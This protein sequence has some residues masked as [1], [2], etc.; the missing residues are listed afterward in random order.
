MPTLHLTNLA[1]RTQHGPGRRLCAMARPR[2]WEHGDGKIM[3]AMPMGY[4]LDAIHKGEI[5]LDTYRERCVAAFTYRHVEQDRF[6]P[7]RLR[8]VVP[9]EDG[10]HHNVPVVDGDTL[11]CACARPGSPKRTHPCHLEWLAPFL[12]AVGWSVVLYGAPQPL[13]ELP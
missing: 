6:T 8:A 1:S 7:G 11:F 3:V 10:R 12:A 2:Q 13:P 9:H 4:D 5:D